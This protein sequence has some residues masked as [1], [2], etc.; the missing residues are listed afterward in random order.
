MQ[1]ITVYRWDN[2][3]KIKDPIGVVF[4]KRKTERANNYLDLLRLA[5]KLFGV[6]T[7]DAV[8]VIID[9]SHTRRTI[10]PERTRE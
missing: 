10:L 4:E 6:N 5:R 8:H 2:G 1:A 9:L 7:S 3:R